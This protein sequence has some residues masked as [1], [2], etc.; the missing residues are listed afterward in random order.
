MGGASL[1][2]GSASLSNAGIVYVMLKNWS[3][4]RQA[5]RIRFR[6]TRRSKGLAAVQEA[7][8]RD[9]AAAIQGLGLA[10]GFQMQVEL[11]DGTSTTAS[12]SR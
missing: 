7:A 10:G 9:P 11:T 6:S 2:D 5:E 3:K 1:F 8:P 12:S 4:P